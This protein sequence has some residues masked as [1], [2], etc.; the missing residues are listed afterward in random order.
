MVQHNHVESMPVNIHLV[1]WRSQDLKTQLNLLV[2]WRF[3]RLDKIRIVSL[4]L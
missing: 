1:I 2:K 4:T 3:I